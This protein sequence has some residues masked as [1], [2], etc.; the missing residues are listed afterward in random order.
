MLLISFFKMKTYDLP[1]QASAR[2]NETLVI[3]KNR[4]K[5]FII[6]KSPFKYKKTREQFGLKEGFITFKF[7][8]SYV[9][10]K[11]VNLFYKY[12]A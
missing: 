2:V 1:S 10:I 9:S 3:S 4:F 5:K 8:N 6:M 7:T 12:Y 11:I